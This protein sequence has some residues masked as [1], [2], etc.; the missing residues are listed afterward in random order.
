MT[1]AKMFE[2]P[3]GS[4]EVETGMGVGIG[5]S[6]IADGCVFATKGAPM[7]SKAPGD[8]DVMSGGLTEVSGRSI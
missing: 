4:A 6:E 7:A 3:R 2:A 8:A 5:R 1:P